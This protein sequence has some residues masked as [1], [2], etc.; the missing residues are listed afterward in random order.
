[1]EEN[2][3]AKRRIEDKKQANLN[4][5]ILDKEGKKIGYFEDGEWHKKK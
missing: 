1:M 2:K 5:D 4:F 3:K